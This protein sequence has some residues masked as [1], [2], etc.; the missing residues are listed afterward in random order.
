MGLVIIFA[1][2]AL[3]CL[4]GTFRS[5]KQKAMLAVFFAGA[6]TLVF[7]WFAVMT[8]IGILGGHG[9]PTAH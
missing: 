3:L 4:A 8:F 1:L 6:S 9:V 2:V 5:L 7:G